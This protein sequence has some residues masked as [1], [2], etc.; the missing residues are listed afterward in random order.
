MAY[1]VVF[2]K[3]VIEYKDAGHT[4]K[5]IQEAFGV[6][7]KR[8]YSWKKMLEQTGLLEYKI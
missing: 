3:R 1:D 5:D 4:F 8:Y 2:R 6:D 7:S